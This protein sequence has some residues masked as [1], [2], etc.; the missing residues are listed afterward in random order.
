MYNAPIVYG[1]IYILLFVFCHCQM[2]IELRHLVLSAYLQAHNAYD[3][4]QRFRFLTETFEINR[5]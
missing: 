3:V 2:S 1:A 5:P 4:L